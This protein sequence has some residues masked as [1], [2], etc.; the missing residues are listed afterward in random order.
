MN[1]DT[2]ATNLHNDLERVQTLKEKGL[3]AYFELSIKQ[4]HQRKIREGIQRIKQTVED[5]AYRAKIKQ[6]E[7]SDQRANDHRK[8]GED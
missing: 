4:G 2:L 5:M 8:Y 7:R 1:L 6:Q 3:R